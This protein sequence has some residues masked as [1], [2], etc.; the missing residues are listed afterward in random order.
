MEKREL[1]HLAEAKFVRVGLSRV[2]DRRGILVDEGLRGK[3]VSEER[4]IAGSFELW[5]VVP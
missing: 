3:K 1:G 2:F 5:E 4:R